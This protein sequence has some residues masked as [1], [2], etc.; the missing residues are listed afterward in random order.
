MLIVYNRKDNF[1]IIC[2]ATDYNIISKHTWYLLAKGYPRTAI[3]CA[4]GKQKLLYLHR[5]LMNPPTHMEVDHINGIRHDNRRENLRIV[6]TSENQ[7]NRKSAKGY[8]WNKR[9][10]KYRAKI[11]V[12]YKVIYLGYYN[13]EDEARQ[14]YLDAKKSYHP[15]SPI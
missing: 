3:K 7:H 13:T 1:E 14:A 8:S 12:N 10:R 6:T 4:S 9:D 11:V 15:T 2:D 5:L